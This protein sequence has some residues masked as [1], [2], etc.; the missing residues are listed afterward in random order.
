MG[1]IFRNMTLTQSEKTL[2]AAKVKANELGI[3]MNIATVDAGANLISF[4]RMDGALLG[5][6]DI[7]MKK[8]KTAGLFNMNTGEL[9][10]L[11]QPGGFLYNIE[12]SNGGLISFAGGV[13]LRDSSDQII[14]AIGV[15]G[16]SVEQDHEVAIA[17][18][19]AL[20]YETK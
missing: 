14:G 11:T 15:S 13:V 6:A 4:C 5:C 16:G 19:N 10:K 8:A 1:N 12:H 17:G 9:G 18:A 3:P 20:L 2:D 7:A